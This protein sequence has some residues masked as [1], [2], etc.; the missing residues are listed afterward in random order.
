MSILEKILVAS[1]LDQDVLDSWQ[2]IL[3]LAFSDFVKFTKIR[4]SAD[5]A[6]LFRDEGSS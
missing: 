2:V 1:A 6:I 4:D 3:C 5:S